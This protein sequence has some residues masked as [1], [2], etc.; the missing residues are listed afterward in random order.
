MVAAFVFTVYGLILCIASVVVGI[1][2][3]LTIPGTLCVSFILT[4][5][6][7]TFIL[8][9][10]AILV[11]VRFSRMCEED[12]IQYAPKGDASYSSGFALIV[13]AWCLAVVNLLLL[14][15]LLFCM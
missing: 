5:L 9:V 12:G 7:V 3:L 1:L 10:W 4:I 13:T 2:S 11:A 8:I 14:I 15:I 6:S